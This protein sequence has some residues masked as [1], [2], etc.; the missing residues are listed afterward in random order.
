NGYYNVSFD[1]P[2]CN[3]YYRIELWSSDGTTLLNQTIILW[4]T[5]LPYRIDFKLPGECWQGLTPG[6]WKN[7]LDAW[8]DTG[9]SPEDSLDGVFDND[10]TGV[11]LDQY[12]LLDALRFKGGRG[13]NGSERILLRAAVAA[14]LN[15][16][17]PNI[18]YPL[19]ESDIVDAVNEALQSNDR[20]TILGLAEL[21]D[22]YNN[23]GL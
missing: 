12:T 16:A 21:L 15:A 20:G 22:S 3:E 10:D 13:V 9:H 19:T 23:L 11:P 2:W 8:E 17:H 18:N 14:I 7:H 5:W 4:E 6:F 1:L